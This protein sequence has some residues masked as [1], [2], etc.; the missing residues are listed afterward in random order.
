MVGTT[1]R[2]VYFYANDG[3]HGMELWRTDGTSAGTIM[4]GDIEPGPKGILYEGG[5]RGQVLKDG[6]LVLRITTAAFGS[7]LWVTDGTVEGTRIL[8][9]WNVGA[10]GS[11]PDNLIAAGGKVFFTLNGDS[12]WVTDGSEAGTTK[13]HTA[14]FQ[15]AIFVREFQQKVVLWSG[16]DVL[17][18]DGISGGAELVAQKDGFGTPMVNGASLACGG[19]FFWWDGSR[20]LRYTNGT[21]AGSGVLFVSTWNGALGCR[22]GALAFGGKDEAHGTE[23]WWSDGVVPDARLLKDINPGTSS[24][25]PSQFAELGNRLLFAAGTAANGEELWITDGTAD[26]TVLV[27]DIAP[28]TGSSNISNITVLGSVAIFRAGPADSQM[29]WA[30]DGTAGGTRSSDQLFPHI[31][32]RNPEQITHVPGGIFFTASSGTTRREL[33]FLPVTVDA[34]ATSDAVEFYHS[35]VDHYFVSADPAEV[36]GLDSGVLTGWARTGYTF[37]V[38]PASAPTPQG[39]TPVCRFYGRPE[40]GLASHFYSASPRECA[41]VEELLSREWQKESMNVFQVY[42]PDT[43]TGACPPNSVPIYRVFNRRSDANHRYT[44]YPAV[45]DEMVRKGGVAEGYGPGP[46]YPVMCS[47]E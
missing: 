12:L 20:N 28:F 42:L 39:A 14:S 24:S 17:V 16:T 30:T 3:I 40:A 45:V 44:I 9:D 18:F 33:W 13:V 8:R 15:A 37:K 25:S 46:Y 38:V 31:G 41:L 29:L 22:N 4:L 47:P 10:A 2:H 23:L 32:L 43:K 7:E 26:G 21:R 35:G 11:N 6:R 19:R 34:A 27:A 5:N 36:H 1:E